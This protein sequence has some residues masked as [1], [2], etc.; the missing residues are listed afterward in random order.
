MDKKL[1]TS[2]V[3]SSSNNGD[4]LSNGTENNWNDGTRSPTNENTLDKPE[5]DYVSEYTK[6]LRLSDEEASKLETFDQLDQL[7]WFIE[8]VTLTAG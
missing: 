6:V 8:V 3:L 4:F 5:F 7:D 2:Q 1:R